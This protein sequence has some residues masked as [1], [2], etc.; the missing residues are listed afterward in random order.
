MVRLIFSAIMLVLL[1]ACGTGLEPSSKIVQRALA[2]QLE[3]TQQQLSQ[4]LD[5]KVNSFE[6][7]SVAISQQQRQKIQDLP[8]YHVQGNY[9][10]TLKLPRRRVTQKNPFDI[11]LQ[12]QKEG[13]TWRLAIP[14]SSG[15]GTSRTWRTYLIF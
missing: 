9:N 7:N 6:I 4:Q 12:R 8:A 13:K 3:Q 14:Q 2:L 1:T 5:L 15:K 11:Y 10:V